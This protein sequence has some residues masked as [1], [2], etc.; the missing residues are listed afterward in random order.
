[1]IILPHRVKIIENHFF[2]FSFG[3]ED[4][5]VIPDKEVFNNLSSAEQYYLASIYN[6]D[7]GVTVMQ[8]IVESDVCDKGTAT[9]IFWMAEPDYFFD[10]D[11]NTID[12]Y[13]KD[14]FNLLQLILERFKR[15]DF[16]SSKFRFIPENE[17]Y[18][19]NWETAK[20]IWE[21]PEDLIR[22]NKG[23]VPLVFG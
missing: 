10:Y 14:V 18:Q 6:W 8:W 16:K 22:G 4:D 3:S 5:D 19:T 20:G 13:E 15:K 21:L 1:M 12:E 9:R 17:G 7:D 2:E 23:I 11:A